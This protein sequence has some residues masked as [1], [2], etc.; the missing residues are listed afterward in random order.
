M[1]EQPGPVARAALALTDWSERWLPDAFIFALLATVLVIVAALTRDPL[2]SSA[3]RR[4]LGPRLLG[5]DP[6]HAP[7]G[8]DH[9]HRPRPRDVAADGPRH[10]DDRLMAPHAARRGGARDVRH[11]RG[12]V[13]Q[14]GLQPDLRRGARDRGRAAGRRRGLP[15]ARGGERARRRQ[16][17]GAGPERIRRA[18]DGDRRRAPAAD[19][20]HRRARRRG[21]RRH[22]L[23]PPHHL[24]L[25]KLRVG[26]GR[27]GRRHVGDVA[28]HAARRPRPHR[29]RSRDRSRRADRGQTGVRRRGQTPV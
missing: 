15:R 29:A 22:H 6:V 5:A 8:A 28:G 27:D 1:T 26:G 24:S 2:R 12:V 14:L 9:H 7:D 20:R 23:L 21:A 11:A 17:L 13:V 18:A 3:G 16:H 10:P 25:A 19:S 4:R